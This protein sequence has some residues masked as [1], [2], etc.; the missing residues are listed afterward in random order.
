MI[1]YS[2]FIL[3]GVFSGL[4]AGLLGIGG[5][6]V[7]VP[8]LLML[9][10]LIGLQDNGHLVHL[11]IGTSLATIMFSSMASIYTHHKYQGILWSLFAKIAPGIVIGSIVGASI[12]HFLPGELLKKIFGVLEV[13]IALQMGLGKQPAAHRTLPG[14]IPLNALGITVG[15]I[16]TIMGM[17]GG[18]MTT[19]FF[20]WCN[21]TARNAI[22]T[23]AAI[24]LPTS[25]AGAAGYVVTGWGVPDLPA[26]SLGYI[27]LPA[28]LGIVIPSLIF[29]PIG[30]NLTHKLPATTLKRIFAVV[31]VIFGIN[32]LVH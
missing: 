3:L 23:S 13:L 29:A 4:A 24:G 12:A 5:G 27:Y 10:P 7:V 32:M 31:L 1:E 22:A 28:L 21:V 25:L 20:M 2:V 16:G 30:A 6:L 11:A 17:G 19:P 26:W 18:A 8:I 14:A 15:G 9:F